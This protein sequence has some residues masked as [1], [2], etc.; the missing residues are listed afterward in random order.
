MSP[1]GTNV[2]SE[3]R[4]DIESNLNEGFVKALPPAG[5]V[6]YWPEWIE[7]TAADELFRSLCDQVDWQSRSIRM[8]G[9]VLKQ[10]RLIGFQGD[11][12]VCYRYSGGDYIAQPWHPDV[13]AL[14]SRLNRFISSQLDRVEKKPQHAVRFNSVLINRY[15]NGQD[16]MGWHADNEKALGRNPL[17]ASIS[18]GTERRFV[19]RALADKQRYGLLPKHGSLILMAG[20][21]QHHW[22]HELPKTQKKIQQRINLTFRTVIE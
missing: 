3:L 20:D 21:L 8:F 5:Q 17:I 19:F 7:R 15:R 10:P 11:E 13:L 22:Q 12:G 9:R 14:R 16:S 18:L 1:V 6:F 4:I 2:V